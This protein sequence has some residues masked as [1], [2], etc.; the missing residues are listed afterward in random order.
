M[1]ARQ[2]VALGICLAVSVSEVA[3][4]Q[5]IQIVPNIPG[6][7]PQV[8]TSISPIYQ[9]R[10]T[11]HIVMN[12]F[13]GE[14]VEQSTNVVGLGSLDGD[15]P[16]YIVTH[17]WQ[18][19]GAT[20]VDADWDFASKSRQE[21]LTTTLAALKKRFLDEDKEIGVN[22]SPIKANIIL[23]EWAGAHTG[24]TVLVDGKGS[25][26]ARDNADYAGMLLGKA[27]A[28]G[29]SN[30]YSQDLHFI[31][32]SYGTVVNGVAARYL[33]NTGTYYGGE[34][35]VQFTTLD[36]PTMPDDAAP[37]LSPEWFYANL[38]YQVDFMD[39]YYGSGPKA[40]GESITHI[41]NQKVDYDHGGVWDFY[42]DLIVNGP[43][44]DTK[45]F[46]KD[47]G[48][49]THSFDDWYSPLLDN[50]SHEPAFVKA[51]IY[52]SEAKKDL[53]DN[54]YVGDFTSLINADA[55]GVQIYDF[56][57]C[58]GLIQNLIY[59]CVGKTSELFQF[60]GVKIKEQ[61]PVAFSQEITF[62]DD[63][64]L[65]AFDWLITE[66]GDGDW[67]SLFFDETL[68]WNMG[69]DTF[70]EGREFNYLADISSFAGL[71]GDLTFSLNS[72]GE[73]NAELY[74]SNLAS[75][76]ISAVRPVSEPN[77]FLLFGL[78]G[79]ALLRRRKT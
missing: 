11:S 50:F 32:H 9:V 77:T 59:D 3:A 8:P 69:I 62:Q 56:I 30:N 28:D 45:P 75:M 38:P 19:D 27:L 5:I 15:A 42:E 35:T 23:V 51:F 71:T 24:T 20:I 70:L 17:G 40:F 76:N 55:I 6:P 21:D 25:R 14:N 78:A 18:R 64:Q 13:D 73:S 52:D 1:I 57:D 68:I 53:W 66:G 37:R 39:N 63:A 10:L 54:P 29:F 16:T 60:E 72:V 41:V 43:K 26:A 4:L 36:S 67:F 61:S 7:E 44:A 33:A 58:G 48:Y 12:T 22:G 79:L 46:G 34:Q 47:S 49:Y 2:L 31:G 65:L 74:I